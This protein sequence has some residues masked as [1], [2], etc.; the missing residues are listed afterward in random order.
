MH[1]PP[2]TRPLTGSLPG[3]TAALALM[4]IIASAGCAAA[5]ATSIGDREFLSVNVTDGGAPRPLAPNT[6]I[7]LNFSGANLGASAG[8]N[9]IGG[10]YRVEGGKLVFQGG[11][12][13]EMGC[14]QARHDQDDWLVAF[15]ASKPVAR[16]TGNDLTLESGSVVMSLRDRTVVEP[17]ANIVGPTWTLVSMIQGDA[18]SSVPQDQS[19]TLKF[20]ADSSFELFAGCNRGGGTWKAVGGGIQ[21]SEILLT[22]MACDGPASAIESAMLVVLEADSSS[23]EIKS[24]LLTLRAGANGLQLEAK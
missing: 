20:N 3:L 23:A 12:M 13:T 10:T 7:R 5:T 4:A 14:D 2:T 6:Q 19:A 16:L 15:L 1:T 11:G 21:F 24:N 9:S 17:D 8:C 18:V 22:K